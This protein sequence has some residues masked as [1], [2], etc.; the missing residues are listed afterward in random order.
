MCVCKSESLG[1]SSV[2]L[3][4]L[5]PAPFLSVKAV[6]MRRETCRQER[7]RWDVKPEEALHGKK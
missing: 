7:K 5:S 3:P 4:A 2:V 6:M 1:T